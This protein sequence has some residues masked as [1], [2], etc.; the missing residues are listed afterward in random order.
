MDAF[1]STLGDLFASGPGLLFLV[2]VTATIVI[3]WDWR[4]T[5]AGV[6]IVLLGTSSIQSVLHGAQPVLIVSQW[7]AALLSTGLLA[8]AGIFHPSTPSVHT[9][10]NWLVRMLALVFFF[11]AW[12]F[13]DPGL[14]FPLISQV[15]TDLLLWISGCG[16]LMLAFTGNAL[17]TGAGLL[18]ISV[19]LQALATILLPGSGLTVI[20]GIGQI[21]LA[22]ACAYLTLAEPASERAVT[23][24]IQR[25]VLPRRAPRQ[26]GPEAALPQAGVTQSVAGAGSGNTLDTHILSEQSR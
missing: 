1:F 16:L 18:L 17:F 5:L 10:S 12:W 24:Q 15:E 26:M 22:L 14:K 7:L 23:A 2:A 8:A 21:L 4:L 3:V 20:V 6:A 19:L 25:R 9:A 11:G 13:L